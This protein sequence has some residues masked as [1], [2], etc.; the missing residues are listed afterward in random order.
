MNPPCGCGPNRYLTSEAMPYRPPVGAALSLMPDLEKD[1]QE[2]QATVEA[3]GSPA[4]FEGPLARRCRPAREP[5]RTSLLG[6]APTR[7]RHR[8]CLRRH[9][10]A[11]AAS[12]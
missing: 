5:P 3:A 11:A 4:V 9:S 7:I 6:S 1:G 12:P 2:A 8:C 10:P